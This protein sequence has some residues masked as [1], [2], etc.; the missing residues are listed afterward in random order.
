MDELFR[1]LQLRQSE[2]LSEE[3]KQLVGLRLYPT[4]NYSPLASDLIDLNKGANAEATVDRRLEEYSHTAK[5]L[6]DSTQLPPAV[7][8]TYDWL[9]FKAMPITPD[10]LASFVSSLNPFKPGSCSTR[11]L[12]TAKPPVVAGEVF[13]VLVAAAR[14]G[15]DRA[16]V[17]NGQGSVFS[18]QQTVG[19]ERRLVHIAVFARPVE[20]D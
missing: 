12:V 19:V 20:V 13:R 15:S 8:A 9:N 2:K 7:R 18:R 14:C 1:F 3:Q 5:V 10:A 16:V 17:E 4:D 11:E 6:E